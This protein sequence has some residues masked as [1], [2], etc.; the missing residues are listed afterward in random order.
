MSPDVCAAEV[1]SEADIPLALECG[2]IIKLPHLSAV[3]Q[4]CYYHCR[5]LMAT[6]WFLWELHDLLSS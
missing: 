5:W 3:G 4:G 1:W 2:S 6:G